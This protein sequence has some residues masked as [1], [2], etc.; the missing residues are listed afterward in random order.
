[1]HRHSLSLITSLTSLGLW[2]I[3]ASALYLG[4]CSSPTATVTNQVYTPEQLQQ[5]ARSIAVKVLSGDNRGSGTL[6]SRQG[7]GQNQVYTVLTNSH[8]VTPGQ[9]YRIETPDG[10]VYPAELKGGELVE[11]FAGKDAALLEFRSSNDYPVATQ[12]GNSP[13][14]GDKVLAA[15]FPYDGDGLVF[16]PGTVELLSDP[17]L[18]GGYQVGYSSEIQQGM[19]G[20]PVLNS[21]GELVAI[22]GMAAFPILQQAYTYMDGSRP[23]DGLRQQMNRL[24]W[25]VPVAMLVPPNSNTGQNRPLTGLAA[26]VDEI[27]AKI[28]VRIEAETGNGSGVIVAQKKNLLSGNTYYVATATHVVENKAKYE[29]VTPDGKRYPVNYGKVKRFPGVDLAVLQFSSRETYPVATLAEYKLGVEERQFV[30]LSGWPG[31]QPGNPFQREFTAGRAFSEARGSVAVKDASSLAN[32]YELVYSNWS[33][34]GMSGGPVL[35]TQG[36]VIGIHTAAEGDDLYQV[37]LG[38]S[39]GVPIRTLIGLASQAGIKPEWLK[40]ETVPP[41][42]L[43]E[44]ETI[45]SIIATLLTL[46]ELSATGSYEDWVNYGNQLWRV[47]S[48]EIAIDAFNQAIKIKPNLYPAWYGKGLALKGD[49]KY[50]EAIAAFDRVIQIQS[51]ISEAWQERGDA[52]AQLK[53]YPQALASIDAAIKHSRQPDFKLYALRG[54]WLYEL[55]RYSEAVDAYSEAIK[56]KPHLFAYVN[57]GTAWRNLKEYQKAIADYNQAINLDPKFAQA[58]NNRGIAWYELKEYEKAIADFTQAINLDPKLAQA[59]YNRGFAWESLKEYEKAIADFNQAINLDSKYAK[60]YVNRGATWGSL[61][62]YEKAI[63]DYNQAI[64]LDPKY[65]EAYSNRGATWESLKEYEKAIADFNQAINL[66]PKDAAA[67]YNRGATWRSLKEYQ[68]AIADYTQ[69]INLDPELAEAYFGRGYS[70]YEQG[71][72]ERGIRDMKKAEQLFCPQ[73][74]PE[75]EKARGILKQ[76]GE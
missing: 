62:E 58:Y 37:Q 26:E 63:A 42:E 46:E 52:F 59:Y 32:G 54:S 17:A 13:T 53:D 33:Q 11:N 10:Q 20:G 22:N 28:T 36:R 68:K 41:R 27:A 9:P 23:D 3:P 7:D 65:A 15:G 73:G 25:G 2:L 72:K 40:V 44:K 43:T 39:L 51:N 45:D 14:V 74:R 50:R 66:D 69:A 24:S 6:I 8:V 64:N 12:T 35:D 47:G 30:F 67:Y 5:I 60:A 21:Q 70:Y 55:E 57:R 31:V 48:N 19:S 71:N 16:A 75:C 1:M 61:K 34:G 49:E 56:I 38:Y 18:Q 4:G 76:L 29:V